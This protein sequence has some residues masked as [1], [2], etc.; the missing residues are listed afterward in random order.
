[1]TRLSPPT[2]YRCPACA[3]YFTRTVLTFLH[4]YDDVPE[5]SDG[6]NEQWWAGIGS[7]AGRCPSCLTVLWVDDATALIRE[8]WEPRAIGRWSRLWYLLTGDRS[9]RLREERE[10]ALLPREIKKAERFIGL[11]TVQDYIDALAQSAPLVPSREEYLRRKLWWA[12]ND[13]L[14]RES[15]APAL[16]ADAARANMERLLVLLPATA[17]ILERVELY[18]QLGRFQAALDLIRSAPPDQWAKARLQQQWAEA[19]DSSMR[20]IPP[21]IAAYVRRPQGGAVVR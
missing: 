13:H 20:V 16:A 11:N 17:S 7:P 12:S 6:K 18:R 3:D 15:N 14:R 8:H 4:F 2:L 10:W 5:W 1:M 21:Q 9:G 19:G